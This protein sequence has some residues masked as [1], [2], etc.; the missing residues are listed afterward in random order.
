MNVRV[1][2]ESATFVGTAYSQALSDE[3]DLLGQNDILFVTAAGNTGDDNDD[4]VGSPL[5]VRLQPP[6]GDLR[7]RLGPVRPQAELGQLR[8]HDGRPRRPGREHLLDA[9]ATAPTGTSAVARWP[10]R[11]WRA[12]PP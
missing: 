12:P 9:C 5:P 7:H 10:R 11:R 3:I 4:L 8:R 6:D 2:N 1:V